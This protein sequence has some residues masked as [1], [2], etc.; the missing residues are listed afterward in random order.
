MQRGGT[1]RPMRQRVLANSA[2]P[3]QCRPAGPACAAAGMLAASR[4]CRRSNG[5]SGSPRGSRGTC[6]R[7]AQRAGVSNERLAGI[8]G[9]RTVWQAWQQGRRQAWTPRQAARTGCKQPRPGG[10]RASPSSSRCSMLSRDGQNPTTN[11]HSQAGTATYHQA[12]R[13]DPLPVPAPLTQQ[14]TGPAR[15]RGRG[16]PHSCARMGR[17]M[18]TPAAGRVGRP[19]PPAAATEPAWFGVE[20][21]VRKKGDGRATNCRPTGC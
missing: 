18:A 13:L 15:Q 4:G 8:K 14:R 7:H 11:V 10:N 16:G 6:G 12:W 17:G 20:G 2:Q 21:R 9:G 19:P 1:S 5:L 3:G